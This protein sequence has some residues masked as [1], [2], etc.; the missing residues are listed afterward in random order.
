[1]LTVLVPTRGRPH[2]VHEV[3][4]AVAST[5][6]RDDTEL[7]FGVDDTDP[8]LI[9]Y[10]DAVDAAGV[11]W[12]RLLQ[13]GTTTMVDC[14]NEL[15]AAAV[16]YERDGRPVQ[17]LMFMGDD[18]RPRTLGWD[19]TLLYAA[20]TDGAGPGIAYG[21]DL[22]QGRNLPTQ[23][24]LDMRI[25][26]QLGGMAPNSLTHLYVD[27]YWLTLGQGAG[28][29][30]YVDNVVIEHCHPITGR[31]VSDAGYERVNAG[32]MYVRDSAAFELLEKDGTLAEHIRLVRV[33]RAAWSVEA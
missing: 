15:A 10:H 25:V 1:M 28:C 5:R 18:H 29:L 20:T 9:R 16:G 17:A 32:S 8:E 27:N 19:A 3:I 7:W 24:V 13:T 33:L 11:S 14:L 2:R 26:E 12:A 22:V 31:Y 21:N 4:E 23:V 6:G 30:R